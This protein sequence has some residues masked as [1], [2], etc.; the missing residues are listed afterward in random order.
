MGLLLDVAVHPADIQ[1]RDGAKMVINRLAVSASA[2]DLGRRRIR[3]PAGR[4]G[5]NSYGLRPGD[6]AASEEEPQFRG[7]ASKMGCRKNAGVDMPDADG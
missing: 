4:M 5:P 2:I 7:F 6:C 1:D 3:W